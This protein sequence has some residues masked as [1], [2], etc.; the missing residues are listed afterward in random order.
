MACANWKRW[1]GWGTGP[2]EA[3]ALRRE[4]CA[5]AQLRFGLHRV[6]NRPEERLR[7]DYQKTTAARLGF[8]DDVESPAV[9]KMM[10]GFYRSATVVRRISDRLLQRFEEQFDGEAV[11]EPVS[12]GFSLRRGYG[13]QRPQWPQGDIE[14]VFALFSSWAYNPI[15]RGLHSLT[16]RAL[17]EALAE[18]PAYTGPALPRASSS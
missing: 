11:P 2:D 16:A 5:L 4:R 7:F 12:V 15:L 8:A 13:R 18:L 9:E 14:Q 6:A 1:S 3:A 17:A 10:Q